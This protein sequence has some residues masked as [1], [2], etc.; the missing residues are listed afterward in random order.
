M[1]TIIWSLLALLESS[2]FK[3]WVLENDLL[4]I[5]REAVLLINTD[6]RFCC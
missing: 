1:A 2:T 3:L 5:G 4:T 6:Q